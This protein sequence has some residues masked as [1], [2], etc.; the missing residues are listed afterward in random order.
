MADAERSKFDRMA[1]LCVA[2]PLV[3]HLSRGS[4]Q[5]IP[6]LAFTL[7]GM[8]AVRQLREGSRAFRLQDINNANA[9]LAFL[10][11]APVNVAA[12]D[13]GPFSRPRGGMEP[14][15]KVLADNPCHAFARCLRVH[16]IA[17]ALG[18]DLLAVTDSLAHVRSLS[19][20]GPGL[21]PL[22]DAAARAGN[23]RTL[24]L[25]FD[26]DVGQGLSALDLSAHTRLR[27]I[28]QLRAS[29]TENLALTDVT[30]PQALRHV[31][32]KFLWCAPIVSIDLSAT[33]LTTAGD[34]FMD[35]CSSLQHVHLPA[36][37]T[38]LGEN[39]FGTC[40][41]LTVLDLSHT[42]LAT[43]GG[44]FLTCCSALMDVRLPATLRR[45]GRSA[46]ASNTALPLLDLSHTRLAHV[47]EYFA[48]NCE[49]LARV[50]LPPSLE[51]LGKDALEACPQALVDW[52][53]GTFADAEAL[54]Q[55][56]AYHR[57]Q[58]YTC[59]A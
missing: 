21:G 37:L 4:L 5:P 34:F 43:V 18:A 13:C 33:Q 59:T 50:A 51:A 1:R 39:P 29:G 12:L 19:L 9:S 58:Q 25:R 46:F 16:G 15:L 53:R 26:D 28:D 48:Y 41:S 52:P 7:L 3:E 57:Q 45:L 14:L 40:V 55:E 23:L 49:K 44:G 30:L 20:S 54:E 38:S 56:N 31:G 27:R 24:S 35:A 2:S 11:D 36:T 10:R 47:G 22:L 17:S 42:A 6:A 8:S 32:R